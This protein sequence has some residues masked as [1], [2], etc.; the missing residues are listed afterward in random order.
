MKFATKVFTEWPWYA[1]HYVNQLVI[2]LPAEI[3]FDNNWILDIFTEANQT[4]K[5]LQVFY[6]H[7][8]QLNWAS[9]WTGE[10]FQYLKLDVR[11]HSLSTIHL[12]FCTCGWQVCNDW[13]VECQEWCIQLWC[14]LAWTFDRAKACWSYITTWAAEFSYMGTEL[15]YSFLTSSTSA[16]FSSI[17]DIKI[18]CLCNQADYR[19]VLTCVRLHQNLV[20]TRLG[21]VLIQDLM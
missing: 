19:K 18:F 8:W 9:A 21:N 3:F 11:L 5:R 16:L 4:S 10:V 15:C 13:T 12:S 14:C 7:F 2:L 1:L 20:K 6:L 17:L